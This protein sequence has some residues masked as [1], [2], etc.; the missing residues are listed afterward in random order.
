MAS[1]GKKILIV[2]SEFE[3]F[4][5][6]GHLGRVTF[7]L[8]CTLNQLGSDA[9]IVIPKYD[10]IPKEYTE[11]AALLHEFEVTLGRR[12]YPCSVYK[13][14]FKE[15]PV[16]LVSA[17]EYF[18]QE[19]VYTNVSND[20]ERF[21]CYCFAV[22][23]MLSFLDF[24]PDIIQCHDWQISYIPILYTTNLEHLVYRKNFKL[25]FVIHSMQYQGI[26]SRYDMLDLLDLPS[27]FF[28]PSTL[29][30]YGQANSLKGG[31]LFSN[32]LVT[33]SQTYAKEIKH[34]Y[35]GENLEGIIRNRY[36]DLKGIMCGID[37]DL[38]NPMTDTEIHA[39]YDFSTH[40]EKKT[41]NKLHLQKLVS[42]KK[43]PNIPLICIT[44]DVL[45]YNKGMDLIKR[46]FDDII[47]LDI[48]LLVAHKTKSGFSAY[49]K[50]KAVEFPGKVAYIDCNHT[51]SET[52]LL[53]GSDILLRPSRVEPCGEKHLIAL[54][55]GTIPIVRETGGLADIV[56]PYDEETGEGN[57]F[58]FTNYNAHDMLYTINRALDIYM[59]NRP[60]WDQL[61]EKGMRVE[62]S[63]IDTAKKYREIYTS[64]R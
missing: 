26:C 30:F 15:V 16:Y 60:L 39:N 31:L 53:S 7:N 22:L 35:Y 20:I 58:S 46:V 44:S 49:F 32:K 12:Q 29:E 47:R 17:G 13:T 56:V 11:N 25:L 41:L 4:T 57:G 6:V 23:K 59:N 50:S 43:D 24:D 45:D 27:E 34:S 63:W 5:K 62:C 14:E 64:L 3:P 42:L 38:F 28:S 61:I 9:R 54:R 40:Q 8:A 55:Y 1:K 48:Q 33:V 36:S 21:A 37:M 52:Q 10:S 2:A 19:Q 18:D 51:I